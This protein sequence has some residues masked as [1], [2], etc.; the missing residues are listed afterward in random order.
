MLKELVSFIVKHLVDHPESVSVTE[1]SGKQS[2]IVELKVASVDLGK[3]IGKEGRTAKALRTLVH[4]TGTKDK[5]K[6]VLEI[7]E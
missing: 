1:I 4:A 2:T 6:V 5:K 7:L 3:V